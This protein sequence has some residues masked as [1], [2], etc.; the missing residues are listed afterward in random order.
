MNDEDEFTRW[1]KPMLN[2]LRLWYG[3]NEYT[4]DFVVKATRTP[5]QLAFLAVVYRAV[6]T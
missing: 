1:F 6:R 3:P 5:C 2:D 4:P